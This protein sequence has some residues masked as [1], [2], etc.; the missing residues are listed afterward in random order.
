MILLDIIKSSINY[1]TGKLS[2]PKHIN[3][4]TIQMDDGKTFQVIRYMKL[5]KAETDKA[6]TL[7]IRFKFDKYSHEKNIKLSR[8]PMFMIAGF[9]GF[10]TK[11]WMIDYEEGY[12]QGV[13]GWDSPGSIEKYIKS[14]VLGIMN[15]RAKKGTVNYTTLENIKVE[16]FVK[17]RLITKTQNE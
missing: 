17:E 16:D 6:S 4:A 7:I 11:I 1:L 8:I 9:K 13:Y 12:W 3:G 5:K 14:T 15:K 2:F 10:R